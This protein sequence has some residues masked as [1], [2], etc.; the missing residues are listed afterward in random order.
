MRR[1]RSCWRRKGSE[2][3]FT[4]RLI[5]ARCC[6]LLYRKRIL[7]R[8][9]TFVRDNPVVH[10]WWPTTV[11]LAAINPSGF[12]PI[13]VRLPVVEVY[14][15]AMVPRNS[16]L[17]ESFWH[18]RRLTTLKPQYVLTM[19]IS[20]GTF[21]VRTTV[22]FVPQNIPTFC[23]S[24]WVLCLVRSLQCNFFSAPLYPNPWR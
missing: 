4:A 12:R 5:A 11:T 20:V 2:A 3:T 9:P 13:L 21:I 1:F 16:I 24:H 6:I 14:P 22:G 19:D 17:G 23:S 7:V 18:G 10:V 15:W 8:G